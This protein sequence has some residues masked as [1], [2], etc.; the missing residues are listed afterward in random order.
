[1]L[2]TMMSE[3]RAAPKRQRGW[4]RRESVLAARALAWQEGQDDHGCR[5]S[6]H[7]HSIIPIMPAALD[8]RFSTKATMTAGLRSH[9]MLLAWNTTTV[10]T[11][12][13]MPR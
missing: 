4:Q 1:M 6:V 10:G 13:S 12:S 11:S 9:A 5:T 3:E 2:A 7:Q 8:S